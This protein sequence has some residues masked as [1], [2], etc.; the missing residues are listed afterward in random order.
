MF[1]RKSYDITVLCHSS[2]LVG[3]FPG[4]S[5]VDCSFVT[6]LDGTISER[7]KYSENKYSCLINK[8]NLNKQMHKM[9]YSHGQKLCNFN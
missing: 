4:D 9:L 6:S 2:C 7:K 8:K 1:K 5:A 3:G